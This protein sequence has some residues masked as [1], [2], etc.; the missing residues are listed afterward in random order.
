MISVSKSPV[1]LLPIAAHFLVAHGTLERTYVAEGVFGAFVLLTLMGQLFLRQ[2]Y[3]KG[4]KA[5][6][7]P[8]LLPLILY[9][10]I[11]N[12]LY[13]LASGNNVDKVVGLVAAFASIAIFATVLSGYSFDAE[14]CA[15]LLYC[16][17]LLGVVVAIQV[18]FNYV[19]GSVT[20]SGRSTGYLYGEA[21]QRSLTLP[22]MPIALSAA[23][24]LALAHP[25]QRVRGIFMLLAPIL[26]VGIAVTVTRA[27]VIAVAGGAI[28]SLL[29]LRISGGVH[30]FRSKADMA[31]SGAIAII[32]LFTFADALL[33]V[34]DAILG[35]TV[36]G[37]IGDENTILGR[38]DE[39]SA[40]LEGFALDPLLGQGLGYQ[41][42]FPS[43]YDLQLSILGTAVP[44]SHFFFVLGAAGLVGVLVYYGLQF[45]AFRRIALAISR[46]KEGDIEQKV[47]CTAFL[48]GFLGGALFTLSS[49][50]FTVVGYNFFVGAFVYFSLIVGASATKRR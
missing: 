15:W 22:Q 33:A 16:F 14:D 30:V 27:M 20:E 21:E 13:S 32:G 42:W 17:V 24:P 18:I 45:G 29:I 3:W 10:C 49:T 2:S 1:L 8:V 40:A 36:G 34:L 44:H 43:P 5:K 25:N 7:W 26:V 23:I 48:S 41:F 28:A 39:Y 12:P 37:D 47:V 31:V 19:T 50:T 46:E 38:L 35:R 6:I 4:P 11:A 9:F